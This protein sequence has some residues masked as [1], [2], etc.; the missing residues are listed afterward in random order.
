MVLVVVL[1]V[2]DSVIARGYSFGRRRA[3]AFVSCRGLWIG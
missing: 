1:V 2:V 3:G